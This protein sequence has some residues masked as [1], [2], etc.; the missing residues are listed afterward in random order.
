M[1]LDIDIAVARAR[2]REAE[3]AMRHP[4]DPDPPQQYGDRGECAVCGRPLDR[5]PEPDG[6]LFC[7]NHD[8]DDLRAMEEHFEERRREAQVERLAGTQRENWD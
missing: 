1:G 4:D 2:R 6:Y 8:E 7:D 3:T 5:P